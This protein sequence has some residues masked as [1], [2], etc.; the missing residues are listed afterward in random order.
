V[1]LVGTPNVDR[2]VNMIM[3]QDTTILIQS[4]SDFSNTNVA[5]TS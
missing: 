4:E 3:L 5:V 2:A 1:F